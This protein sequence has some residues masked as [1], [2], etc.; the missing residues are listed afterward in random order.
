MVCLMP[1][2]RVTL[3][4]RSLCLMLV[5]LEAV[6]RCHLTPNVPS[7]TGAATAS[8]DK[9]D[10]RLKKSCNDHLDDRSNLVP[11]VNTSSVFTKE[12]SMSITSTADHS[13]SN[14]R[15]AARQSIGAGALPD[16]LLRMQTVVEITGL[17][18]A[19]IYRK[20]DEGQFPQPVR[21]GKR[22]TRWKAADIR[23]WVSA[24]RVS[25]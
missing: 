20:L 19:T 7:D 12:G 21:L 4:L 1:V 8:A 17:S 9:A 18:S 25:L 11:A 15:R 24:Q 13:S 5:R 16:A 10:D 3:L 6:Y 2:E 23:A 14:A 22:C